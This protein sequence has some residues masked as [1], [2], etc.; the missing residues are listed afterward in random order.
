MIKQLIE[1]TYRQSELNTLRRLSRMIE[2]VLINRVLHFLRDLCFVF[3]MQT[4]IL[5]FD[6]GSAKFE[7]DNQ[8]RRAIGS[9]AATVLATISVDIG[10]VALAITR[11]LPE[12]GVC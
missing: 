11:L 10:L 12:K 8:Q 2:L 1:N 7:C 6:I 9:F 4:M 5:I 3:R